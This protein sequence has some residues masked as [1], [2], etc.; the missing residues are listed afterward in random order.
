[1][2]ELTFN[3]VAGAVLATALAIVGL[4]ELSSIVYQTEPLKK[5]GYD[6]PIMVEAAGGAAA[7]EAP[8]DWGTVLP[9]ADVA[10]GQ[11]ATAA[12]QT[13]HNFAKDG[14]NMT[15]PNLYGVV[16]RKPGSH[17]G[18]AYSP[19][20]VAEGD[21]LGA[22]TYDELN[23]FLSGPQAYVQGTK[24][25]FVGLKKQDTR[26][27]VIAYLRSLSDSPAPIPPPAPKGA[28]PASAGPSAAPASAASDAAGKAASGAM[29]A[30]AAPSSA[31][32]GGSS[33]KP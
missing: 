1:M 22:W 8:P 19:G 26:I 4:E 12:C 2:G 29:A 32:A 10:A 21:K 7:P 24:M 17:P 6:V 27:N 25:T 15:G 28:A 33:A 23:T 3:K 5:P 18:F 20:M 31:P 13:C 14:P 11:A 16:G 9:T 30:P